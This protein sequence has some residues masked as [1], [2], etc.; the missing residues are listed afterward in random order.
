M[1]AQYN[2]VIT[3]DPTEGG[4]AANGGPRCGVY[5]INQ[6]AGY[7]RSP[8]GGTATI[9]GT[10]KETVTYFVAGVP[11]AWPNGF[12]S[13]GLNTVNPNAVLVITPPSSPNYYYPYDA[14]PYF[15]SPNGL[16]VANNVAQARNQDGFILISAGEDRTYGTTDD[17]TSFG[18]VLP[19]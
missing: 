3:D 17:I 18:S 8:S 11:T 5:D 13:Q 16:N 15:A 2:P 19:Q 6:I 10:E 4:A 12:Q 1:S 14:F 9:I 7:T